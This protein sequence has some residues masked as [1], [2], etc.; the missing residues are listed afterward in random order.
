MRWYYALFRHS[1]NARL[2]DGKKIRYPGIEEV[3]VLQ[4][5]HETHLSGH[6]VVRIETS[7]RKDV[8]PMGFAIAT[9]I[10]AEHAPDRCN[11]TKGEIVEDERTHLIHVVPALHS[12]ISADPP[13]KEKLMAQYEAS[14][15]K[16]EGVSLDWYIFLSS[17]GLLPEMTKW[18]KEVI[19]HILNLPDPCAWAEEDILDG[20]TVI[21]VSHGGLIEPVEALAEFLLL[22][23]RAKI[24]DFIFTGLLQ[25][26]ILG[27]K[28][29]ECCAGILLT[30]EDGKII[31]LKHLPR[32]QL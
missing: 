16:K 19:Q 10:P 6:N 5:I 30:I 13:R 2:A 31:H 21:G 22:N 1:H 14:S 23:E 7:P 4:K 28:P 9:S 25:C 8:P 15:E 17:V 11:L 20:N 29:L 24:K 3:L 26:T 27:G 32:P 12:R 18:A